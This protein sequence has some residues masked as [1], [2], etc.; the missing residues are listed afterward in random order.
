MT[1]P[2]CKSTSGNIC[3]KQ[4]TE[5]LPALWFIAK[6]LHR[7]YK[8]VCVRCRG[9]K[10]VHGMEDDFS[11]FHTDNFLP[12]HLHS[13]LNFYLYSIPYQGKFRPKATRNLYQTFAT[14]SVP[15]QVVTRRENKTVWYNVSY[16]IF[17]TLSQ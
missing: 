3:H 6:T 17:K 9:L 14:L 11:V 12:L 15:L 7:E 4:K 2:S 1:A 13:M 10:P 16:P 5:S 8:V